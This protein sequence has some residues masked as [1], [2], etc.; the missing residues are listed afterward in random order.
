MIKRDKLIIKIKYDG[1]WCMFKI[2]YNLTKEYIINAYPDMRI[3]GE[4]IPERT[5]NYEVYL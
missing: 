3:Y 4:I 2:S 5:R 1:S